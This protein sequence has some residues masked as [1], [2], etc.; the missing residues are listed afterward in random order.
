MCKLTRMLQLAEIVENQ[1]FMMAWG[2]VERHTMP[3]IE[4]NVQISANVVIAG[5]VKVG[6]DTIIGANVTISRD[7]MPHSMVYVPFS[8]SK[9][10]WYVNYGYKGFYCNQ[11]YQEQ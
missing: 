9:R 10:K 6:H 3:I 11:E 7:V 8:L 5:P 1:Q 2:G 4:D